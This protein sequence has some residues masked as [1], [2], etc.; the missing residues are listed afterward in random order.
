MEISKLLTN[1]V[2]KNVVGPTSNNIQK[3]CIDS[4]LVDAGSL[5]VAV[6]GTQTDGHQYIEQAIKQGAKGILCEVLPE[7]LNPEV[8]YIEVSHSED[9]LGLIAAN[10]YDNPSTKLKLVGITG[11]NGKTTVA[12]ILY[13]A[14]RKLG[15][16]AGL[17]STVCNFIDTKEVPADHTTPDV[18]TTNSLLAEMVEAGCEYAFMEVSS[19]AIDQKRIANLAFE[20][21]VFTN[22]TRDHLDYH[23]TVA[24]YLKAKKTFFDDLPQTAF[25]LVNADDKNG[26][27]MLQNTKSKT[28]T[29]SLRTMADFKAK[30]LELHF[31]GMDLEI[32]NKEVIMQLT[33]RFNASNL[34]AVYGTAI[35]LGQDPDEVLVALS[36]LRPVTG[37][38]QTLNSPSGYTVIIDYAHTPDALVNVLTTIHDILNGDGSVIT[39]VGAGGNRDKGKR[40]IMAQEAVNH[41]DRVIITSDNPRF[42]KPQDIIND[43]L[44]GLTNAQKSSVLSIESRRDA[45]KTACML[46]RPGDVILIAGKGHETYQDIQG[47][48]HHFDDREEVYNIFQTQNN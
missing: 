3:V 35:L 11:T 28:H 30:I 32:D 46:A 18:I 2:T 5:F 47:V 36:S 27:V 19:H 39:V 31:N 48:K 6:K 26:L 21:G 29:Y 14:F 44:E 13:E 45:I 8:C 4:R 10:F 17:I 7:I 42:E 20:G 15:Y 12:T 22:L 40:P 1:V 41:S 24:N 25:S 9:A 43:M 16:K 33:G 34:L 23:K 37:R 38:F